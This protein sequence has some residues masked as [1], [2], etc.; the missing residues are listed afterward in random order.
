MTTEESPK[1]VAVPITTA[2]VVSSSSVS[3]SNSN[4]SDEEEIYDVMGVDED[5]SN[6]HVR[7]RPQRKHGKLDRLSLENVSWEASGSSFG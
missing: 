5:N 2:T 6:N 3:S 4:A 1:K 7:W